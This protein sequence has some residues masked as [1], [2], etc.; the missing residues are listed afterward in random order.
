MRQTQI[1]AISGITGPYLS[2]L[3]QGKKDNPSPEI[4][5]AL[6][7][8]LGVSVSWLFA[9]EGP[10]RPI[11]SDVAGSTG[12]VVESPNYN[13]AVEAA[14]PTRGHDSVLSAVKKLIEESEIKGLEARRTVDQVIGILKGA[15]YL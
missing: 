13:P 1:A 12:L 3:K 4:V 11:P 6:A 5:K 10:M 2:D 8:C 14:P 9:G 7:S 15:G